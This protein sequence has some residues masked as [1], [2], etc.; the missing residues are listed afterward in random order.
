MTLQQLKYVCEIVERGFSVSKAAM[1]LH[2][3]QPSMSRQIQALEK[4]LAVTI[5]VRSKRRLLDLTNPGAEVYAVA[6]KTLRA[7]DSLRHIGKDFFAKDSGT[8]V[9]TTSHTHAR[10]VLPKV[11]QAFTKM[12]PKVR[13]SLRQGNPLQVAEWV[14]SGE[15][16][17]LICSKPVR[18]V[19][20]LVLLPCYD[21]HKVVLVPRGHA[22][23][24][25]RP[26]TIEAL[27]QYP[28]ITYDTDFPTHSQ[29][30]RAFDQ[31][32]LEPNVILSATDVDVMKAYVKCGL[33]VAIVAALAYDSREDREVRAIEAKHL[34]QSNKIYIGVQKHA[35]LRNYAFDF[36]RL[37]APTVTQEKVEQAMAAF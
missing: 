27:A 33:G 7:T 9:V 11:I 8:L 6:R 34:F 3:S 23:L 26:L 10:Y 4:E 29:V 13:V 35:Y 36:M 1:A 22:L 32:G 18:A 16:D 21:Q 15:A 24:E 20:G 37:F 14:S 5:F 2:T 17:L 19:P 28:L 30:M 31:H 12:Y 25:S